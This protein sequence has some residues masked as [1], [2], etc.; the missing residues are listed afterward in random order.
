[1]SWR[2]SVRLSGS[3]SNIRYAGF[4]T[5][6]VLTM[7]SANAPRASHFGPRQFPAS[8]PI[9]RP[10]GQTRRESE[11]A[12]LNLSRDK[13]AQRRAIPLILWDGSGSDCECESWRT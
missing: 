7:Q 11:L 10:L 6:L 8:W 12:D 1:M 5:E 9:E 13:A 4:M 2:G 3:L